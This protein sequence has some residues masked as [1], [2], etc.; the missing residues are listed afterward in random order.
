M[1]C[2]S[3]ATLSIKIRYFGTLLITVIFNHFKLCLEQ[4]QQVLRGKGTCGQRNV[5]NTA[6]SIFS[7]WTTKGQK[8]VVRSSLVKRTV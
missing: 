7:T 2:N 3:N 1:K 5:E 8:Q 4:S 6:Y